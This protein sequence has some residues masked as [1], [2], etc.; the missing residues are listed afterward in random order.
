[1][2]KIITL[3]L[4]V[5]S[6]T[7]IAQPKIN[8]NVPAPAAAAP[9]PKGPIPYLLKK[10]FDEILTGLKSDIASA[11]ASNAALKR[12][13]NAKDAQIATLE[14]ELKKINDVLNIT[15]L[16][17]DNTSDSLNQTRFSLEEMQKINDARFDAAQKHQADSDATMMMYLGIVAI[18]LVVIILAVYMM[19]NK[20][21]ANLKSSIAI[22][23]SG[24]E[25]SMDSNLKRVH[26]EMD[27]R[28]KNVSEENQFYTERWAN[29][30][31]S[32]MQL[33]R[34]EM[35][36]LREDLN[37][38]RSEIASL[39]EQITVLNEKKNPS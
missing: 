19:L 1:M 22:H 15:Q 8:R 32:E 16:K 14:E 27:E 24:I 33:M 35:V 4:I 13:V 38:S 21:A 25:A 5:A 17:A 18:V 3:L 31:K 30:I 2:K 23:A 28:F 9:K 10:D 29:T 39:N 11:T 6:L 34:N 37:A 7:A 26:T 36:K 12:Q 20:K